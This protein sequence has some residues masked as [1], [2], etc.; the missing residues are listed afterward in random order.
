LFRIVWPAIAFLLLGA[1]FS[2]SGV[3]PGTLLAIGLAAALIVPHRR[4]P[5]IATVGLG[6]ATLEWLRTLYVLVSARTTMNLPWGR[7]SLIIAG[8]AAFTALSALVFRNARVRAWYG[9]A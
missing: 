6:L 3:L 4:V 5:A 9:I 1:H 2:R 7:L 8:V